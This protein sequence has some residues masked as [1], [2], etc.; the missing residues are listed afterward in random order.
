MRCMK[1]GWSADTRMARSGGSGRSPGRKRSRCSSAS[2]PP[3][4]KPGYRP[5]VTEAVYVAYADHAAFAIK[6]KDAVKVYFEARHVLAE[7][8]DGTLSEVFRQPSATAVV[9][10]ADV[11]LTSPSAGSLQIV[12]T[13]NALAGF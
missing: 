2:P 8:P 3:S 13:P 7:A 12:V 5:A 11:A 4:P 1:R 9:Q 10:I 6:T